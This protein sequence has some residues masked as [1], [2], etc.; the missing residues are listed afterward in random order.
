[1][2]RVS[3][4]SSLSP[5]ATRGSSAID[6]GK[7]SGVDMG[8]KA[9]PS[10]TSGGIGV[11]QEVGNIGGLTVTGGV[12]IEVS[13]VAI[14]ISASPSENSI[15]ISG[16]A[17]LPGGLL[18]VSGGTTIDTSTGEIIGGSI[19]GEIG[20]VGINVSS[21]KGKLGIEFTYQIPFSP[22]EISLGFGSLPK[23]PTATPTPTP[24]PSPSLPPGALSPQQIDTGLLSSPCG[25]LCVTLHNHFDSDPENPYV[26]GTEGICL[27]PRRVRNSATG[28]LTNQTI[29]SW[30]NEYVDEVWDDEVKSSLA[31]WDEAFK[32]YSIGGNSDY[33]TV[34]P[35]TRAQCFSNFSPPSPSPVSVPFPNPPPRRQNVDTCCQENL[36]FLRAIYGKLGLAKFP[37]ELPAT[38]I[39]EVPN[40]GEEP[41][42]PPQVPIPDLV[43]L[44]DWQFRRDD[45]RW[46]QWEVQINVKDADVTQEG[47]QGKQVKFPN[48]AESIAE[49]EGQMLS[50]TTNIDAL[51]AITTKNL[52]ESG[53]SRQEAIKGYLASKS[54]IKYMAFKTQEIDVTVPLCF[55]PGAESIDALVKESELH[56]KGLDYTEKETL[57][58]V[59]LDLL[60]AAA[61]I[62][63]VHWQRID[64]KTDTKSQLLGILKGSLDLA[65]SI[66]NP[67]RPTEGEARQPNPAQNFEDFLD[68]AESGFTNTTGI[69]DIQ[70]PYG[71]TPDRR[72]RIRQI[73]DNISQAGDNN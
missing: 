30:D 58:D 52:V 25:T 38:I 72:P 5:S 70:N 63:A 73:G 31:S 57:R 66:K 29:T 13:P 9:R 45:E 27:K 32:L 22:I 4:K 21:D 15:S 23:E 54:I 47:D 41:A 26:T 51:I 50:L 55:T 6:L 71:K 48:L 33:Y 19:G 67:T 61:I 53:L 69:T 8:R 24:T 49:I 40:E 68:S 34:S 42:E 65:N 10:V 37:G 44:L 2:S 36:K 12:S 56:L 14:N 35:A 18:G 16:S 64:T 11:T 7:D 1:M 62:R 39:Q 20:G 46:G 3:R 43:S 28:N 59:F 17:E 60:Q